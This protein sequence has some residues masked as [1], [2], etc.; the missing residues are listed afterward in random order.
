MREHSRWMRGAIALAAAAAVAAGLAPSARAQT[1]AADT[2]SAGRAALPGH[3]P[4]GEP[5]LGR[6]R[7]ARQPGVVYV[8]TAQGG[9][10]KTDDGGINW[11]PI[12]D[13]Q[14]VGPIGA[15]AMAPS[16]HNVIWV[17]TGETWMIRPFY[18]MG[19]GMYVSTDSGRTWQHRGLEQSGHISRIVIDPHNPDRVFACVLGET[20]KPGQQQG[21][22]SPTT[23][24]GTGSG[25]CS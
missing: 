8:G 1:M 2:E 14:D 10:F 9:I 20:F 23:A 24:A 22:S 19:D 3:R 11:R 5:A 15:L 18:A 25:R 13:D 7:R 16:A 21:S 12:F 6:H 17:G 4:S